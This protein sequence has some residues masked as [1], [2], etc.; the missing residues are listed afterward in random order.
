M[1]VLKGYVDDKNVYFV[2]LEKD[3]MFG[4][5]FDVRICTETIDTATLFDDI[6][7]VE[8]LCR[9]LGGTFQIFPVCPICKTEYDSYPAISRRDN[10]TK[11]CSECGVTEAL[12]DFIKYNKKTT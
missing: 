7:E 12:V 1:Y 4:T 6:D 5:E 11:I 10:K 3:T 2:R 8:V 9:E